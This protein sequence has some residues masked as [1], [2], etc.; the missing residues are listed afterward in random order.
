MNKKPSSIAD[1]LESHEIEACRKYL[2]AKVFKSKYISDKTRFEFR[3]FWLLKNG[4]AIIN[5]TDLARKLGMR[6]DTAFKMMK[7]LTEGKRPRV[8]KVRGLTGKPIRGDRRP[9]MY[10]L[11]HD[12]LP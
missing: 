8:R 6:K 12:L 5:I 4:P 1:L 9:A 10:E 2:E 3:V 7:A 11:R